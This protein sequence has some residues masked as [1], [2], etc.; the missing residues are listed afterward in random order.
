MP[1]VGTP[2]SVCDPTH[3]RLHELTR[4]RKAF[5]SIENH[6]LLFT[7][8]IEPRLGN[9]RLSAV[10]TMEV[11]QWLHPLPTSSQFES[12]AEVRFVDP[13]PPRHPT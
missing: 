1:D 4:E 8:F 2:K 5:S 13:L 3:Y 11:E 7:R 6:R 12:K 9:R 10:P